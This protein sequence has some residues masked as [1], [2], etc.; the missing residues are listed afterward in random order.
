MTYSAS[1]IVLL[2]PNL[3]IGTTFGG[4]V[5]KL[6][7]AIHA[8]FDKLPKS[9]HYNKLLLDGTFALVNH[10]LDNGQH[11][12]SLQ[13]LEKA[14]QTF[15]NY[16]KIVRN[17]VQLLESIFNLHYSDFVHHDLSLLNSIYKLLLLKYHKGFP[18][19]K[20]LLETLVDRLVSLKDTVNEGVES[21]NTFYIAELFLNLYGDLTRDEQI[22][23]FTDILT[24]EILRW[25]ALLDESDE[26]KESIDN[27]DDTED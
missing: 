19:E 10:F 21:K 2:Y 23:E 27:I 26:K 18:Q 12:K 3:N 16:R 11:Y 9:R 7:S 24:P 4:Q 15:P 13:L 22:E 1:F 14:R 17:E 25:L 5:K 20:L 6:E 8:G